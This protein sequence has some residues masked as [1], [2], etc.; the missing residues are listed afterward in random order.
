MSL[1][2]NGYMGSPERIGSKSI[3][4]SQSEQLQLNELL[5]SFDFDSLDEIIAARAREV[6]YSNLPLRA[7]RADA[8]YQLKTDK[9]GDYDPQS[10]SIGLGVRKVEWNAAEAGIDAKKLATH[11]IIHEEM[12]AISG[13][14]YVLEY[15]PFKLD[16][17]VGFDQRTQ[18]KP[19]M[20][21][22]WNEGVT[23]KL[24]REMYEKY[25][26]AKRSATVE[27]IRAYMER[28]EEYGRGAKEFYQPEVD[29]VNAFIEK[30]AKEVGVPTAL[31]W[32]SITQGLLRGEKWSAEEFEELARDILPPNFMSDLENISVHEA[33]ERLA[34][35]LGQE[36]TS[37]ALKTSKIAR[38][39]IRTTE[40]YTESLKKLS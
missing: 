5:E 8:F 9:K 3:E 2:Y 37:G 27:E 23:E 16:A 19:R 25:A 7:L 34:Q 17:Q 38:K 20:F 6:G 14:H 24:A 18:T 13:Q 39:I 30:V 35:E 12:H 28:V 15:E 22:L 33:A 32:G 36:K 1:G 29:L 40:K 31:V 26:V 10:K 21:W 11:G 4:T